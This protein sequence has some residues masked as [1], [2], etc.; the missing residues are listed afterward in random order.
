M[1]DRLYYVRKDRLF[2]FR[3]MQKNRPL[4]YSYTSSARNASARAVSVYRDRKNPDGRGYARHHAARF[5]FERLHDEWFIV[6]DPTFYFTHDGFQPHRY[7]ETLLSGKIRA[8]RHRTVDYIRSGRAAPAL[9]AA[10]RP[11]ALPRG[12]RVFR[13]P[14]KP[15]DDV[16]PVGG[17][18][19]AESLPHRQGVA[20]GWTDGRCPAMRPRACEYIADTL[21]IGGWI[22]RS[23]PTGDAEI[24]ALPAALHAR[25]LRLLETMEH[26]GREAL[27]APHV[28]PLDGKLWELRGRGEGGIARGGCVTTAGRQGGVRYVFA[29]QSDPAPCA[30]NR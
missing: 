2:Y 22:G 18:P 14:P 27:R 10:S 21:Y 6:I 15:L 3:A 1:F 25:Q 7:P 5:R 9:R 12:S 30:R 24:A 20:D 29:K 16:R 28:K 19:R 4:K 23:K 26:G 8:Q 11:L 17:G 13:E